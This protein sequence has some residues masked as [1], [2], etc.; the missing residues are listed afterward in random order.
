MERL[1][2]LPTMT[3][4]DIDRHDHNLQRCN[5][6]GPNDAIGVMMLLDGSRRGTADANAIATHHEG[7]RCAI[8]VEIGGVHRCA[9]LR[10]QLKHVP[11]L[12]AAY[13]SQR[14]AAPGAR[15]SLTHQPH[16]DVA[17]DTEIAPVI[18]IT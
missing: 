4:G 17:I 9:I 15:I 12:N 6:Y 7:M 8:D 3:I 10:A 16:V 18:G 11:D 2:G 13:D 14:F 1:G 5:G